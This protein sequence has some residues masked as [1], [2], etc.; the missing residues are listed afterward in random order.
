MP[1]CRIGP[2]PVQTR[3]VAEDNIRRHGQDLKEER[4]AR[5]SADQEIRD[6]M[7]ATETGGLHISAMGALWILEGVTMGTI[8]T[9]VAGW[10][11]VYSPRLW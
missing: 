1:N 5:D 9:E 3:T 11:S 10:I 7:K 2:R 8:P 4:R 6:K